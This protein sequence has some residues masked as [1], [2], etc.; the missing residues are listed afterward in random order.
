MLKA[1]LHLA[2]ARGVEPRGIATLIRFGSTVLSASHAAQ[3]ASS[4][5]EGYEMLK[6]LDR[7]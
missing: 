3:G 5:M 2:I 4:P 7:R 6:G 1:C